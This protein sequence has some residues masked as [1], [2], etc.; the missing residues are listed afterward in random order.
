MG[1]EFRHRDGERVDRGMERVDR[2]GEREWTE[3]WREWTEGWRESGQRDGECGQY[4]RPVR[5]VLLILSL[6]LS[7]PHPPSGFVQGDPGSSPQFISFHPNFSK[8]ALLTVVRTFF[9]A[10]DPD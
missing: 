1:R 6:A 2:D 9:S 5:V 10:R 3:G 7:L 8:G 4:P